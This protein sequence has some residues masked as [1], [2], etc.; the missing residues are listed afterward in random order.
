MVLLTLLLILGGYL[1]MKRG[2]SK[3]IMEIRQY[4]MD[5]MRETN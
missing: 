5:Y 2:G 3:N 4:Y 1:S